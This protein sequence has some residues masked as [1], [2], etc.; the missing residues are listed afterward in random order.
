MTLEENQG[1]EFKN[2]EAELALKIT[3]LNSPR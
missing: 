1:G 2:Q 3:G